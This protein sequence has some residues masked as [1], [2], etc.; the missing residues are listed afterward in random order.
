M[1][2]ESGCRNHT[3]NGRRKQS[4]GC[5]LGTFL[6]NRDGILIVCHR[7]VKSSEGWMVGR[8]SV[9]IE[10]GPNNDSGRSTRELNERTVY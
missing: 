3:K 2:K 6:R 8:G 4:V 9:A 1:I 10:S 5:R 7:T